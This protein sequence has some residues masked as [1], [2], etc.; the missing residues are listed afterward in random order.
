MPYTPTTGDRLLAAWL[1]LTS[2]L[3]N[4][5]LVSTLT[6]NEAHV[7]GILLRAEDTARVCTATTLIA[8][9]RLLKSQMN[10]LLT[11]LENKGYITRTRSSEDKRVIFIAL[12][13]S[14]EAAYLAEH[15]HVEAIVSQLIAQIGED[16]AQALTQGINE[17]VAALENILESSE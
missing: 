10:K 11:T 9:T 13:E 15:A 6:Y 3:W 16:K 8:Q 12:T 4:K 1:S 7:L 5:R 14:G 17:T 2:T